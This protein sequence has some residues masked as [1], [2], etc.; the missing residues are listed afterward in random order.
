VI[1]SDCHLSLHNHC[2]D[3][4]ENS[5]RLRLALTA[6]RVQTQLQKREEDSIKQFNKKHNEQKSKLSVVF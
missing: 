6:E 3:S 1:V 4:R 5:R 2:I